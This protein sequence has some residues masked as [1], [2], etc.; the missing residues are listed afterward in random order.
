MQAIGPD[1]SRGIRMNQ[2]SGKNDSQNRLAMTRNGSIRRSWSYNGS[3]ATQ[4]TRADA[5]RRRASR[6]Q[7]QS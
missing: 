4:R 2:K 6:L 7:D 5:A 1:L 3:R